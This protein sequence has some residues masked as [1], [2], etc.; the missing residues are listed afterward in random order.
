METGFYALKT[1]EERRAWLREENRRRC[2]AAAA[3]KAG[4]PVEHK[5]WTLNPPAR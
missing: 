2:E 4:K 3:A 1:L 5:E